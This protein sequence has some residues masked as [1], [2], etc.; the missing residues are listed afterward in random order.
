M[1]DKMFP[2]DYKLYKLYKQII[3]T[4]L[5]NIRSIVL[6]INC[7]I[8][9]ALQVSKINPIML[10]GGGEFSFRKGAGSDVF[11]ARKI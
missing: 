2:S 9:F 3:K 11:L 7:D 4:M 8:S 10:V 1:S 5:V 6:L